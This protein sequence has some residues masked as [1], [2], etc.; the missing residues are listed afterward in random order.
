MS[1]SAYASARPRLAQLFYSG[2]G[3]HGAVAFGIVDGDGDREFDHLLG[4]LGIEPLLPAY[5]QKCVR[6]GLGYRYIQAISG[7]PWVAWPK[8]YRWLVEAEPDYILLHSTTALLPCLSYA[9][10]NKVPLISVEHQPNVLKKRSEWVF[11]RL[12]MA[13][14]DRVVVL[15]QQYREELESALGRTFRAERVRLIHNG[16]DVDLFRSSG[17]PF[18]SAGEPVRVGMAAR[19][20]PMKRFDLAVEMLGELMSRAPAID[21]QLTL[22]GDGECKQAVQARAVEL[23]LGQRVRFTGALE[24][25][26]LARWFR[27]LDLYIHITEG[28][29]MSMSILQ[30]MASALPIAASRVRGVD[31][32]LGEGD[33]L[34]LLVSPQSGAAFAEALAGLARDPSRAR[35]MADR[36]REACVRHYSHAEMFRS[37]RE[38]LQEVAA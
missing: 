32:V 24:Q 20:T 16:V 12:G 8:V 13:L 9:R 4:F 26:E 27:H 19:F 10:R 5:E 22:A 25:D 7:R 35:A 38:L 3:G 36:A 2:L 30:A 18:P 28:E 29:T 6:D 37:Y 17:K 14:A 21:W 11:S 23:E 34:G 31:A 33:T 15:T 1:S